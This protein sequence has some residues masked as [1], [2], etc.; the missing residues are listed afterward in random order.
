MIVPSL[1]QHDGSAADTDGHR[2]GR[3]T[4][5]RVLHHTAFAIQN[6]SQRYVSHRHLRGP[7]VVAHS[8]EHT[9]GVGEYGHADGL[10]VRQSEC[11]LLEEV[12]AGAQAAL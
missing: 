2:P 7:L 10:W 12:S 5:Q 6:T 11:D 1:G 8:S 4:A 3:S 9:G